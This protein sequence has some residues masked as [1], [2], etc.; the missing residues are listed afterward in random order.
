[1][2]LDKA[3]PEKSRAGSQGIYA[4]RDISRMPIAAEMVGPQGVNGD[5]HHGST[6]GDSGFLK[7]EPGREAGQ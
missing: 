3:L 2:V 1:M 5:E 6:P 4:G 7:L